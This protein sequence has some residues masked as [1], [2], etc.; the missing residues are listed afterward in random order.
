[1]KAL[2]GVFGS[3]MGQLVKSKLVARE[4]PFQQNF[5]LSPGLS[6]LYSFGSC[7]CWLW[8]HMHDLP[9]GLAG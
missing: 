3:K 4:I 1:M 6:V 7:G 5:Q 8:Q 2:L 9:C